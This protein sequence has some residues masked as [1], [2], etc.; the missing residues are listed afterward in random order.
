[1][2]VLEVEPA[3]S[4]T[5]ANMRVGGHQAVVT[6]DLTTQGKNMGSGQKD[7]RLSRFALRHPILVSLGL[8]TVLGLWGAFLFGSIQGA[9]VCG[10]TT[11]VFIFLLWMPRYG[12]A[13]VYTERILKG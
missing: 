10:L 6:G 4:L 1:M 2:M 9:I 12:P 5:L 13:R 11:F 7:Y 3:C 8:G